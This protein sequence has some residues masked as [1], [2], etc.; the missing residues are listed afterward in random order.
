MAKP[1]AACFD[2]AARVEGRKNSENT[3]TP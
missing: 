2:V 1:K 3:G